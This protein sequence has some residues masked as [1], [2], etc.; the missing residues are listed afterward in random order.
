MGKEN[1]IMFNRIREEKGFTLIEL[2]VVILIIGILIAVAA[3]SFLGQQEKA[4]ISGAKQAVTVAYK[5]AKAD[6]VREDNEGGL[7]RLDVA[8][9]PATTTVDETATAEALTVAAIEQ[10]EPQLNAVEGARV[11]TD[12]AGP[13]GVEVSATGDVLT[14]TSA[15]GK[16]L[17]T[18]V[19][20]VNAG[21]D[22]DAT[23][24]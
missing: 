23:N 17:V 10:S 11:A 6:T 4:R 20:D 3:P 19:A 9:D 18:G 13:V 22:I 5:A 14:L 12:A 24:N 21:W 2:L 15:T 8:D 16:N 7:F 1:H